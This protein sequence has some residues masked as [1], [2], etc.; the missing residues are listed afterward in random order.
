MTPTDQQVA[1]LEA[2]V[3]RLEVLVRQLQGVAATTAT[4]QAPPSPEEVPR[5]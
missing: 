5:G 4:A 1:A 2:R 3:A